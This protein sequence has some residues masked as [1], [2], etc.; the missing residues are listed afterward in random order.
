[1]K[2]RP[3]ITVIGSGAV[4]SAWIDYFR[5]AGFPIASV[6][7]SSSG[8][9]YGSDS[10]HQDERN[11][12]LPAGES[13]IGDLILITT[14][15]SIIRSV[16]ENLSTSDIDW[17]DKRVVH[18]SG[19]HP[20]SVLLPLSQKGAATASMHPIQT[21]KKSDDSGRLKN[22][23]ISLQGDGSF[24][25]QLKGIVEDLNSNPL[26]LDEHQKKAVHISAV[27]ASNY[28][29]ALLNTSDVILKENGVEEGVNI[30]E[31]LIR[32]TLKNILERG[33]EFSL[34]GPI[35]RGDTTTVQDHLENLAADEE[36]ENLYKALG[37]VCLGIVKRQDSLTEEQLS[38]LQRILE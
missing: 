30:L 29:V 21:F 5:K 2:M 25:Q 7:N 11:H 14:P 18:C 4:G 22:I 1:M 28:L 20:A 26:I 27:F 13:D 17:S 12:S 24:V 37:R 23:Y 6:W 33:T 35:S 38:E 36:K 8:V 9:V 34:T 10:E 15:D 32:Q 3:A 31:P 19:S 16:A